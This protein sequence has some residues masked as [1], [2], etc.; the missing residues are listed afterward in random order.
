MTVPVEIIESS[1]VLQVSSSRISFDSE[2]E[3][4]RLSTQAPLSSRRYRSDTGVRSLS[5]ALDTD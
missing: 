3:G 5:M 4:V 1:P 2:A